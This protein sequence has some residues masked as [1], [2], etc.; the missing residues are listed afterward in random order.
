[1]KLRFWY[2]VYGATEDDPSPSEMLNSLRP[3]VDGLIH[4]FVP[5]NEP[6]RSGNFRLS[7]SVA[8]AILVRRTRS[9]DDGFLEELV[10][11]EHW[12]SEMIDEPHRDLIVSHLRKT[13]QVI[14]LVPL[15]TGRK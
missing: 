13:Q 11:M 12:L 5:N 15:G 3:R 9:G 6:W 4:E 1:V 7:S 8:P 10:K 14:H 2:K